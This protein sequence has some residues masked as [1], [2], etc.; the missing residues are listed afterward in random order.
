MTGSEDWLHTPPPLWTTAPQLPSERGS[1]RPSCCRPPSRSSQQECLAGG[2][3]VPA[4]GWGCG[5][6]R[7]PGQR[8]LCKRLGA[9][10]ARLSPR[11]TVQGG[12]REVDP[13]HPCLVVEVRACWLGAGC[14]GRRGIKDYV[15][16]LPFSLQH[17]PVFF[18]ITSMSLVI[19][20]LSESLLNKWTEQRGHLLLHTPDPPLSF[21]WQCDP[22]ACPY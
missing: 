13:F 22:Q 17:L 4:A 8:A 5:G 16:F 20:E 18:P 7:R 19:L 15:Y 2:R 14:M 1:C 12:W 9:A 10:I 21:E 11:S 3:S 6:G